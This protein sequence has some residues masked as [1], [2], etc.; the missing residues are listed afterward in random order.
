MPSTVFC[1]LLF[2][3]HFTELW[4][5]RYGSVKWKTEESHH[6]RIQLRWMGQTEDR[7]HKASSTFQNE[8][9]RWPSERKVENQIQLTPNV[10]R[11]F[12]VFRYQVT[13][14]ILFFF[15]ALFRL[16]SSH[17]L[18]PHRILLYMLAYAL[19]C[20]CWIWLLFCFLFSILWLLCSVEIIFLLSI[21]F[22][23]FFSLSH[24]K[25]DPKWY[26][27]KSYGSKPI[28][29]HSF[30]TFYPSKHLFSFC[31][32][33]LL[34]SFRLDLWL[35]FGSVVLVNMFATYILLELGIAICETFV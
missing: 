24:S 31:L 30:W 8:E 3:F 25:T 20:E 27:T 18:A 21:W 35:L 16:A 28:K 7:R 19:C 5:I 10:L 34:Q 32:F 1:A 11:L 6:N 23:P 4:T 26:M 15:V 33:C 9:F 2:T 13:L 29:S 17:L 22:F 14:V 12:I